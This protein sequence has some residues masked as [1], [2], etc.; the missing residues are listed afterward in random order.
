MLSKSACRVRTTVTPTKNTLD[1]LGLSIEVQS[2]RSKDETFHMNFETSLATAL[3]DAMEEK[4]SDADSVLVFCHEAMSA[5]NSQNYELMCTKIV[6]LNETLT[7]DMLCGTT[8]F[9]RSID[10]TVRM[11]ETNVRLFLHVN[12]RTNV[13]NQDLFTRLNAACTDLGRTLDQAFGAP[14]L[15]RQF[16]EM[17]YTL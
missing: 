8:D 11:V 9:T 1:S 15:K 7:A 5:C 12:A 2:Y 10:S 17:T 3:D 14:R 13:C 6:E 16:A 4:T